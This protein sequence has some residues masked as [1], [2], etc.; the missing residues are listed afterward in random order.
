MRDLQR[1]AIAMAL[2]AA[3]GDD[4]PGQNGNPEPPPPPPPPPT[5]KLAQ[6]SHIEDLVT[7]HEKGSIRHQFKERDF[8][9][10]Q[11]R[12]PFQSFIIAPQHVGPEQKKAEPGPKLCKDDK[13]LAQSYSVS[14]LGLV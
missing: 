1:F 6:M 4:T 7:D 9:V 5:A 14:E 11:N 2:L 3:C 13:V 8:S 12:D 10:E